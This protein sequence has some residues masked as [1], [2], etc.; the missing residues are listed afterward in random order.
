MSASASTTVDVAPP[1]G[2]LASG[3]AGVGGPSMLLSAAS[4]SGRISRAR[5]S[6]LVAD[7]SPALSSGTAS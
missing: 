1:V 6:H 2:T 7:N 5:A 3:R 4:A